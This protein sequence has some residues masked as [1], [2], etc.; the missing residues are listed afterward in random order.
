MSAGQ[1]RVSCAVIGTGAFGKHYVRLLR[2]DPRVTLAAVVSPSAPT[3]EIPLY[4]G[5]QRFTDAQ[6]VWN[7]PSINA[8]I[9]AT[10]LNTH[11]E[12]AMAALAAGKHV[13]LEK[14]LAQNIEE[15][16]KI[17][18]AVEASGKIFMLGHQYLYNDDVAVLKKELGSGRIGTVRYIHAEQLYAGPIRPGVGC[19]REAATHEIAVIDHLFSPGV[20]VSVQASG[21]DLAGGGHEDFAAATIQYESGLFAHIVI[22]QYSPTKSR[23]MIFGGS[24]GVALFDDQ[25]TDDKVVFSL[26]PFPQTEKS[27]Q[28]RS[29]PIPEGDTFIPQM[30]ERREPL[31]QEVEHF[32]D[33]IETGAIPRSDITHAMRV[34]RVL[35]MVS[36]VMHIA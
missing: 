23:R 18:N 2:D 28:T 26:R 12:L 33:C 13:L 17:H 31:A 20:P 24:G 35:D 36:K 8:V 4:P 14:P 19:F 21:I 3:K 29:L 30:T 32:L 25:R 5:I 1:K 15:A 9:I 11:A 22:S 34:E 7:D 27:A 16:R 6:D 10:P